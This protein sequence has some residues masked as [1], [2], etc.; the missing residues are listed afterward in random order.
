MELTEKNLREKEFHNKLQAK[1]SGRFE[2]VFYKAIT[3]AWEDFYNYLKLNIKDAEVLDYGCGIGSVIEKIINFNP[4]KI[5]GIDISDVSIEKA[6]KSLKNFE[7]KVDLLVDN[8]EK[9]K[10]NDSKFDLVYG[11]GILHHLQTTECINEIFRILKPNGSLV[12]IEPLG[13]NPLINFYRWLTPKSRSKDEHPLIAKDFDIIKSKFSSVKFRYYGF[14]T[15]I[16]F[17]FYTSPKNSR[18]FKIVAKFDQLLFKIKIFRLFA[19]S[20]LIV[21]K[22]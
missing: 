7:N 1:S 2:N 11:L 14:L 12:F 22:K 13:N 16:F 9:T 21:A 5:T 17:P 3:N 19:W 20:T 4:K 8:C 15:L 10:F 6:K 18:I